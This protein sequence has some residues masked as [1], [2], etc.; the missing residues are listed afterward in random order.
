VVTVCD[1]IIINLFSASAA[2]PELW[3]NCGDHVGRASYPYVHRHTFGGSGKGGV[4]IHPPPPKYFFLLTFFFLFYCVEERPRKYRNI[5]RT[6]IWMVYSRKI[7]KP[8]ILQ[9]TE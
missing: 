6:I 1:I 2:H 8:C 5:F 4:K 7:W 9:A 3:R